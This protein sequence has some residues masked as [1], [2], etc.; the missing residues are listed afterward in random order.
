MDRTVFLC[1]K[2][3]FIALN[4][5]IFTCKSLHFF[6]VHAKVN[7]KNQKFELNIAK[8]FKYFMFLIL[9]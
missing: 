3:N 8:V 5:K 7:K 1:G 4:V 2:I 9:P 6:T